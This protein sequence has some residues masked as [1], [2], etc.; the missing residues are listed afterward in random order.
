MKPDRRAPLFAMLALLLL[1]PCQGCVTGKQAPLARLGLLDL[2]GWDPDRDGPVALDG[3]WE[4]HWDRLLT[5]EDFPGTAAATQ[6]DFLRLPS[7]W[8]GT[9]TGGRAITR[10]GHATLRLRITPPPGR[11]DLTLRV[12]DLKSAYVLWLDGKPLEA[13]GRVGTT[14]ATEIANPSIRLPS[15]STDGRP[16]ELVLQISNYHFWEGGILAPIRLGPTAAIR[17]DQVRDWVIASFFAGS[18]LVM[19][20][21]HLAL[22]VFREN[23]RSPFFFGC[24]CLL[25]FGTYTCSESSA[26]I[27]SLIFPQAAT[28]RLDQLALICFFLSVPV[29]Y[30]FFHSLYPREFSIPL[31]HLAELWALGFCALA[32]LGSTLALTTGV[33]IYYLTASLLIFYSL[34]MLHRARRHGREGAG[35][36]LVG[37]FFLGLSGVND[38]LFDLGLIGS[39]PVISMGMFVF[40]LFQSLALARRF[41]RAFAAVESLSGELEH[42]NLAL[43]AEM[44]ERTRLASE[45]VTVTE[46]ERRRLSHDLHDGLCQQLSG[47]RLRCSALLRRPIGE[48]GVVEEVSQL[49]SLLED[50][51]SQAYDLS[52]GLWPVE[53]DPQRAGPSLEEL[54]R[55]VSESSGVAIEFA[56]EL[57]CAPCLNEH[58]VQLYRIAQ[59]A[60]ANAVKHAKPSRIRIALGCDA[61]RNLRLSVRDDGIGRKAAARTKGGLGLRIMVHRAR[62]IGATL[63]ITDAPGGGTVVA[64]DLVCAP[65]PMAD[66][67][68]T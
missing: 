42:K 5:P 33:P 25:W 26:W 50:S 22:F 24:Y 31:M 64:C 2:S 60:V 57:A 12:Y 68:E 46:E 53:H 23:S 17:A 44:A 10:Q 28:V 34:F 65:P 3:E 40:I 49:S 43:E 41:S 56:Q 63:A 66:A 29:G 59:E 1:L 36:I 67:N 35:F 19:G 9:T 21:Y 15:F 13:D 6:T 55:R 54:A 27:A 47:A 20:L 61:G 18:L 32:L 37:F 52:R 8:T 16:I 4:C 45:I 7:D 51:V 30:R 62:M 58:L 14:P 11:R 39:I 38:M 48:R